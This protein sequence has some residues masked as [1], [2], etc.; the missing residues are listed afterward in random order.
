MRD[1]LYATFDNPDAAA[2]TVGS[3]LDMGVQKEDISILVK[4]WSTDGA[5]TAQDVRSTAEQGLT[6]T[7]AEDAAE[8]A[9]VGA[10]YGLGVG[11][12]A[13][14]AAVT[15][16]GV[17]V[18]LGGG[19]LAIALAGL[20]G[21][22]AAGAMAGALTGYLKDQ[23]VSDGMAADFATR[24]EAGGAL[25]SVSVPSADVASATVEGVFAKYGGRVGRNNYSA[26][27]ASPV[28]TPLR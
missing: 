12:L 4:N 1:T 16:P 27:P 5:M 25:V 10:G 28:G 22:S 2:R 18:I 15:L 11:A 7:T 20:V 14:L 17:G 24:V 8:G 6:V 9:K 23:G 13:A 19:A 21:T 3:L 26:P